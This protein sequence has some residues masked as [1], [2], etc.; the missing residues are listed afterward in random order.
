MAN[1]PALPDFTLV[2][3]GPGRGEKSSTK[4]SNLNVPKSR[5]RARIAKIER[6]KQR[7][8]K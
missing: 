4:G 6:Q 3:T 5:K 2:Y 1:I 7:K 8:K